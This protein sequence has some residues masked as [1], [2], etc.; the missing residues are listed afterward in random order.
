[1][2]CASFPFPTSHQS[3][4]PSGIRDSRIK[5]L[6]ELFTREKRV[7]PSVGQALNWG[8]KIGKEAVMQDFLF[9]Y[10]FFLM[11]IGFELRVLHLLGRCFT[12]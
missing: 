4:S 12:T 5:C 9:A 1:M 8:D 7:G 11:V 10:F 3:P 6:P 2:V